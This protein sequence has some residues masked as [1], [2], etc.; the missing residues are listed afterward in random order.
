VRS[1]QENGGAGVGWGVR[2]RDFLRSDNGGHTGRP[3]LKKKG[4][5]VFATNSFMAKN[6]EEERGLQRRWGEEEEEA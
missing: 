6:L 2:D 3:L 5:S 1:V 4:K